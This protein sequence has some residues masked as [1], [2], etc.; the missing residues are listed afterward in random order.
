[1]TVAEDLRVGWS[2]P[3]DTLAVGFSDHAVERFSE[4]LR[5]GIDPEEVRRQLSRMLSAA[6]V[7]RRPPE[8][9]RQ[10]PGQHADAFLVV[11]PD[12]VMPLRRRP[13]GELVA[14]TTIGVDTVGDA[15]R[16]K[17]STASRK[18]RSSK[19]AR[20]Y[21]RKHHDRGRP[22]ADPRADEWGS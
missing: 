12:V 16:T 6:V 21:A 4:R 8:W 14:A 17:R 15:S 10:P 19:E 3:G 11:G 1:M 5:P 9:F 13:N 2:L 7:T 22:A 18:L 20:R